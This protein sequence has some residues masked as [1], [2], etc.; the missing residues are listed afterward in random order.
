[1][2]FEE[3]YRF[4]DEQL[5]S[6]THQSKHKQ[7]A[8]RGRAKTYTL[9]L[10]SLRPI[11]IRVELIQCIAASKS[12]KIALGDFPKR[13]LKF[14]NQIQLQHQRLNREVAVFL[15]AVSSTGAAATPPHYQ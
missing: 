10:T 15:L 4:G 6:A 7:L 5:V 3:I 2:K 8:V 12:W 11:Q 9:E 13:L 14:L 1:V